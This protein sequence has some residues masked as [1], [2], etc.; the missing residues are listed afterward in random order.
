M[1]NWIRNEV[2]HLLDFIDNRHVIRRAMILIVLWQL[3]DVYLFAK[4]IAVRPE[5]SGVELAAIIA[6]LTTPPTALMGFLFKT[7]GDGRN[8]V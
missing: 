3:V 1:L 4:V 7:Y 5:M 6:A 2:G 8:S